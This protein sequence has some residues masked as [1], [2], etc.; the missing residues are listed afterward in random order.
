MNI[1]LFCSIYYLLANPTALPL[2]V[3]EATLEFGV[4]LD[5]TI[6]LMVCV[7]EDGKLFLNS[8]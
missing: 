6:H 7:L 1:I 8:T 2:T 3:K 5:P 4:L